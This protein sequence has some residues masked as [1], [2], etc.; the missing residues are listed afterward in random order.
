MSVDA[1]NAEKRKL[2]DV[3]DA[4]AAPVATLPAKRQRSNTRR[5][6]LEEAD[7]QFLF[8]LLVLRPNTKLRELQLALE[9]YRGKKV[10]TTTIR[11][12]ASVKLG[13][14]YSVEPPLKPELNDDVT[15]RQRF[16]YATWLQRVLLSPG[17]S[18]VWVDEAV[19]NFGHLSNFAWPLQRYY[20][21]SISDPAL[22]ARSVSLAAAVGQ[23][24][25][26]G[27][28]TS[29]AEWEDQRRAWCG[30]DA[31]ATQHFFR[32]LLQRLHSREGAAAA[33]SPAGPAGSPHPSALFVVTDSS[34]LERANDVEDLFNAFARDR[35]RYLTAMRMLTDANR[36][37]DLARF[38]PPPHVHMVQLPRHT[39][40]LDNATRCLGT[41]RDAIREVSFSSAKELHAWLHSGAA[42]V[43]HPG[44]VQE[45]FAAC[46]A[47]M[48]PCLAM[49]PIPEGMFNLDRTVRIPLSED[50][51]KA[52]KEVAEGGADQA[53]RAE[54]EEDE[55][56]EEE[57]GLK[58]DGAGGSGLG[59]SDGGDGAASAGAGA[60]AAGAGAD[61]TGAGADAIGANSAAAD[62]IGAGPEAAGSDANIGNGA[63]ADAAGADAAG[64]TLSAAG[65]PAP[66]STAGIAGAP[67]VTVGKPAAAAAAAAT[68]RRLP[69]L[70]PL[71][72]LTGH[73]EQV[74]GALVKPEV[75]EVLELPQQ[76]ADIINALPADAINS[77]TTA[78][79]AAVV[80]GTLP[81]VISEP[82][83]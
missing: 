58:E 55:E 72:F 61:A 68:S 19:V 39:P 83:V 3:A 78:A 41:L 66:G 81:T 75:M 79:L 44:V 34:I 27:F 67:V 50:V 57:G 5:P 71:R 37:D 11:R 25:L 29:N 65:G 63:G 33:A 38:F 9:K 20:D 26:L 43:L 70:E 17:E 12:D 10:S 53:R 74:S 4:S 51:I 28:Q 6:A 7:L 47:M 23:S 18:V 13:F 35:M 42:K 69:P 76:L 2:D 31:A 8:Q 62:I 21:L 77:A 22:H 73:E 32:N 80:P 14:T 54:E 40:F 82:W 49:R 60:D 64:G 52:A 46:T 45:N 59:M 36:L 16:E 48:E 56:D 1:S 30:M 24:Q 15:R